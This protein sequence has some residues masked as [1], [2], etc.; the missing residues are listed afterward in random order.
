MDTEPILKTSYGLCKTWIYKDRVV[1]KFPLAGEQS[2]RIDQIAS[3]ELSSFFLHPG[4]V[5]LETTGG[6]KYDANVNPNDQKKFRDTIY[7]AQQLNKICSKE[8]SEIISEDRN[9][10]KCP[11]C[12]ELIM[13]EAKKCR[14]CGEFLD[15]S[16]NQ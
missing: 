9:K 15:K 13:L 8:T 6:Q 10:K 2:I 11:F 5:I 3:I 7:Q 14:F 4:T 12:A 1:I 16:I